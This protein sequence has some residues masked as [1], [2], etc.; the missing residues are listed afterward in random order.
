MCMNIVYIVI[1]KN[2]Q[3][4]NIVIIVFIPDAGWM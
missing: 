3:F 4:E 1:I 2:K